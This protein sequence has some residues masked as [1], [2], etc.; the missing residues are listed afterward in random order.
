MKNKVFSI[1]L[2]FISVVILATV[3]SAAQI[4]KIGTGHDPAI[5]SNM[6]TWSDTD[7]KLVAINVSEKSVPVILVANFSSNVTSGY[8]P[9]RCSLK[10]FRRK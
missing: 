2:I 9:F 4:T 7:S 10:T 6:I 1:F 3:A 5:Y 8:L